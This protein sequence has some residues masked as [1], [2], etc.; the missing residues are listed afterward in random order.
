[1]ITDEKKVNKIVDMINSNIHDLLVS[2]LKII[3]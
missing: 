3:K 1:M 2:T